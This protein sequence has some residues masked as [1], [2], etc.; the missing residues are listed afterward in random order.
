M[1]KR[2]C[3]QKPKAK[4]GSV[5]PSQATTPGNKMGPCVKKKKKINK[6]ALDWTMPPGFKKIKQ[7][8]ENTG[9]QQ[10]T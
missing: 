3:Y 8:K 5:T 2:K 9:K 1:K 7:G 10:K 4:E 6:K